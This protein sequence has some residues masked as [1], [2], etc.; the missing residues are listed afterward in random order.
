MTVVMKLKKTARYAN[1]TFPVS[2]NGNNRPD[3]TE[4]NNFTIMQ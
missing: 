2:Q 1:T 3:Q 4:K